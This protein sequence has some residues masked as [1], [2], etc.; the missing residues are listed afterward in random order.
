M[1]KE[2]PELASRVTFRPVDFMKDNF[3]TD[4]DAILFGN[5]LH[6]WPVEVMKMLIKKTFDA[7]PSGGKII[8]Y[9]LFLDHGSRD[10]Y[11][12]SLHM[13][14]LCT[15]RQFYFKELEGWLNEAGFV[16]AEFRNL[17]SFS[18]LVIA[19]KE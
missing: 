18:D 19:R 3:P 6:D 11:L 12:V 5:V 7:L 4:V 8:I 10:I 13:Q 16:G 17:T 1:G 15:G 9:D 14:L 2:D